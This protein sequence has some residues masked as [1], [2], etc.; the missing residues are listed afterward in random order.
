MRYM[1]IYKAVESSTPPRPELFE[2]VERF[3]QELAAKGVLVVTDGLLPSS[4]GARV[5]IEHGTLTVTD[6]PF[7]E[8]KE[9]I[10]GYG[11]F[12]VQS[13]AEILEL[14]KRFLKIMGEGESEIRLM[15]DQPAYQRP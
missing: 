13:R 7:T 4:Q 6:G 3:I 8:S 10:A 14:T 12:E 2:Q 5:R 15:Q 9:L 1:G 11:I